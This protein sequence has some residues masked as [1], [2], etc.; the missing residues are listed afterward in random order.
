MDN[1]QKINEI[2]FLDLFSKIWIQTEKDK[3]PNEYKIQVPWQNRISNWS[4]KLNILKNAV[5]ANWNTRPEWSI[6]LFMKDY[7][8]AKDEREVFKWFEENFGIKSKKE[9]PK[10]NISKKKI[11]DDL[12]EFLIWDDFNE[13]KLTAIKAYLFNRWFSRDFLNSEEWVK[14]IKE[15]FSTIWF[16]ENPATRQNKKKE[17]LPT[18][19]VLI[20]PALDQS[21]NIL[22]AKLR[23]VNNLPEDEN[24]KDTKSINIT[25]SHSWQVAGSYMAY[26]TSLAKFCWFTR[27]T[28]THRFSLSKQLL[29]LIGRQRLVAAQLSQHEGNAGILFHDFHAH[30]SLHG[31]WPDCDRPMALQSKGIMVAY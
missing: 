12:L 10:P 3:T 11:L 16:C 22:W 30:E 8:N 2:P 4:Y 31:R 14:R 9:K 21:W 25:W 15:V 17:W 24:S 13:Q 19:P 6:F 26:A 28:K 1:L 20:F 18:K 23:K 5:F 7:L 27:L 29:H